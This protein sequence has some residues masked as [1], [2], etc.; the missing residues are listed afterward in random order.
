[1][2]HG[3][4][5]NT[6][7]RAKDQRKALLR[8]LTR[9]LVMHGQIQITLTKAKVLRPFVEK[10]LTKGK[11]ALASEAETSLHYKRLIASDLFPKSLSDVLARAEKLTDR[12]GGYT[13]ILKLPNRRGDNTPMAILQILDQD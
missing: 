4:K 8:G 13:R 11:K 9:E 7:G 3:K 12:D 2:R 1:M 6:L 5:R 10:L